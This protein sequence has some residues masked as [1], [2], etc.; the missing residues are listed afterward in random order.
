MSHYEVTAKLWI[1]TAADTP[2]EAESIAKTTVDE[3]LYH[4]VNT[5]Q[6]E[7]KNLSISKAKVIWVKDTLKEGK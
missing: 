6:K 3:A 7:T 5:V 2:E 4:Y 1:K